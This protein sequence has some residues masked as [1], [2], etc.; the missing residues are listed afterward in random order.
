LS[1]NEST[2][3]FFISNFRRVLNLVYVLLGMSPVSDCVFPTFRNP[4]SGPSSK[5]PHRAFEDGP[6]RGFRNVDKT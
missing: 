4:L 5:A 6:D 2:P 1:Q 3:K